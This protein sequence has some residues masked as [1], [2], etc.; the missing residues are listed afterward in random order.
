MPGALNTQNWLK[1]FGLDMGN[2]QP[3]DFFSMMMDFQMDAYSN[4]MKAMTIGSTI[5]NMWMWW[6]NNLIPGQK[7][8]E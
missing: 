7:K 1:N 3:P 6:K 5:N 8:E 4:Y 2:P